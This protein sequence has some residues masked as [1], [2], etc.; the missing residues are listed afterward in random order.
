[1]NGKLRDLLLNSLY[2]SVLFFSTNKPNLSFL[3]EINECD[4]EPCLNGGNCTDRLNA[5]SCECLSGWDGHSCEI[6]KWNK[7]T[8]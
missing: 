6:S 2:C 1:M 7:R 8:P 3:V 5:Y 4:S